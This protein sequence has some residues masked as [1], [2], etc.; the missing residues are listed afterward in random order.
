MK[1]KLLLLMVLFTLSVNFALIAQVPTRVG[2]WKFDDA[3][4]MLKAEIGAPL[5]LG[6][7]QTSVAGPIDGNLAT[8]IETGSYLTLTHGIPANLGGTL[9]NEYTIQIDFSVP[10]IGVWNAFFQTNPTN[11]GDG[12]LFLNNNNAIG[13]G[14][15]GYSGKTVS[16][17]TWYRM[18][19]TVRNGEFARVFVNGSLWLDGAAQALDGRFALSST[20]LMFADNDG[21]DLTIKCSEIGIWDVALEDYDIV[22][23]GDA[24]GDRVRLRTKKGSWTFDDP[25]DMLKADVGSP[26]VLTGTQESVAGP[27]AGNLATKLGIGSFL[28]ST[29]GIALNGEETLVNEYSIVMDFTVPA[30]GVWHSFFQTDPTN[31]SDA[32]LF[33]NSND[34]TIG[35]AQT[36]Y[37]TGTVVANTWYRMVISVK[38]GSFFKV[39]LN[40]ELWVD[41][42]GQTMDDRFGL[43]SSLIFFGDNDGDDA[44]IICSEINL[45]EVALT[46]D[47]VTALG[48]DPSNKVPERVG[49]W[50]FD[51]LADLLKAEIGEPLTLTGTQESTAGPVSGNDAVSIGTGSYLT[52]THGISYN[53]GGAMVNEYSLQIDFSIP[54]ASIWHAFFQTAPLNDSDADLFINGGTSTPN[55]IGTAA[56]SYSANTVTAGEWYRMIVVVKNDAFFK[57]YVNGELWVESA[58]QGVDGRFALADVL[59]LFGDDDGDDNTILCSEAGIWDVLLTADQIAKLG[60]ATTNPNVGVFNNKVSQNSDLGQNFPNPFTYSTTFPYKVTKT[61]NVSFKVIDIAGRQIESIDAGVQTPGNYTYNLSANKLAAG[62]YYF[63]MTSDEKTSVR[64]M[65]VVR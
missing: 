17:D 36:G 30:T 26:L 1:R 34:N 42:P 57:V 32:D 33:I 41:A 11:E 53:G 60:N 14:D 59:L 27:A 13:V 49:W 62:T 35:T 29:H 52:M 63:Q 44:E 20:L 4:D 12:D 58:G 48:I 19:I 15:L 9:V 16:A 50:K 2:W 64:K 40:G 23:L 38:N 18:I 37:S 3:A 45:Y 47:E 55:A 54:E 5:Q 39:Y 8:Q 46:A 43:T 31:E 10:Q 6:G 65:I 24:Y 51:D 28:Q 56:T 25:A 22:Q 7:T 21:E 61:G